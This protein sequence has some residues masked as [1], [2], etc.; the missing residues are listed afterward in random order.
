MRSLLTAL[1]G[2]AVLLS[3]A[4]TLAFTPM[5]TPVKIERVKPAREKVPSLRFFKENLDFLRTSLDGLHQVPVER[6]DAPLTV[7]ESLLRYREMME[8]VAAARDTVD[9][10]LA[11]REKE[12][13]LSSVSELAD[14]EAELDLLESIL[15]GQEARLAELEGDFLDRATTAVVVVIR[16]PE[17]FS[18][19]SLEL[20]DGFEEVTRVSL[21]EAQTQSV[22]EGGVLQVYHELVEPRGQ[23]WT[24]SRTGADGTR[25]PAY[26]SFEPVRHRVNFLEIDLRNPDPDAASDLQARAWCHPDLTRDMEGDGRR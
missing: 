5:I 6:D 17:D 14:L 21:T 25:V 22:R 18:P 26:L 10:N 16:G 4:G 2:S 9:G 13:L 20:T 12:A 11:L 1:L 15:D 8:A 19:Q 23:T 7:D 24:V 3:P